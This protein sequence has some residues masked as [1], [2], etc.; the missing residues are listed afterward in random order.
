MIAICYIILTFKI[1]QLSTRNL[2]K[3]IIFNALNWN[4]ISKIHNDS[5]KILIPNSDKP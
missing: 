4:Y 1:S 5:P 3:S 2:S